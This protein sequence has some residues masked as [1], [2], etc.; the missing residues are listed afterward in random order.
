[1]GRLAA[2]WLRL[3]AA[4][5]L[6]LTSACDA[7]RSGRPDVL[8]V[9]LDTVRADRLSAYGHSRQTSRALDA[10]FEERGV[11]FE[12]VTAPASW[13]WP[14]HA[15]LFTGEY[16]WVHGAHYA[17]SIEER[18]SFER[19]D[20]PVTPLRTDLPTLAERFADAGYHTVSLAGNAW[21]HPELGLVRGFR[22]ARTFEDER[23]AVRA[24]GE[25]LARRDRRPLFLFL[26]FTQAHGPYAETR[27]PWLRRHRGSLDR[28]T[29]PDWVRPYLQGRDT[30]TI[31]LALHAEGRA[32]SGY[33][34]YLM[35]RLEIPAAGFELL[36][37]VYDGE[38]G[39]DD[40]LLGAALEIWTG[41]T[42]HDSVVAV[43]SD[44]GEAFGEH[45][46]IEHGGS[47]YP[48]VLQVPLVIAAPGRLP[49]GRRIAEP[50]QMHDLYPTLLDLAGIDSP[51]GSLVAVARGERRARP[52]LAAAWPRREWARS[53]G[54]RLGELWRYYRSNGYAVVSRSDGSAELYHVASDPSMQL[55]LSAERPA[56]AAKL[57]RAAEPLFRS[58][59]SASG[60]PLRPSP[61]TL[62]RLRGLGYVE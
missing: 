26:N 31:D 46:L 57:L 8:L 16:P 3:P 39:H 1:V 51:S 5:L 27:F 20:T 9:V 45:G 19:W 62:E 54:G 60:A 40:L 11:L 52:I 25:L 23:D 42:A 29:A 30:R 4:L 59:G 10:L 41:A 34:R 24:V 47:V 32:F 18:G 58:N 38:V 12:D 28:A 21:L 43:T 2:L 17:E 49:P 15:S 44:H 55:D 37:D 53:A 50:V 14:S 35:G 56:L 61:E 36:L 33:Q 13:T 7:P 48:E 22:D 6:A